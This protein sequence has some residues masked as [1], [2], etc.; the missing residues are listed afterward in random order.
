MDKMSCAENLTSFTE[1]IMSFF[2]LEESAVSANLGGQNFKILS[3]ASDQTMVGPP[4]SKTIWSLDIEC[5]VDGPA[6]QENTKENT[7]KTT[8]INWDWSKKIS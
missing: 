6:Q 8:E 3:G 7:K 5:R 1:S 2:F 4:T